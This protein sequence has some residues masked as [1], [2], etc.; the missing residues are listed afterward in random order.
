MNKLYLKIISLHLPLL[1]AC[2]SAFCSEPPVITGIVRNVLCNGAST[3]SITT[4]TNNGT[5]PFSYFWSNGA[6]TASLT[7]ISAGTYSVTVVDGASSSATATFTVT[8]PSALDVSGG[9]IPTCGSLS[10]GVV[11]LFVSGGTPG[12]G[13]YSFKW[14][15]GTTGQN[16]TS[17]AA[18]TYFVTVTDSFAC[19]VSQSFSITSSALP[20]ATPTAT[21]ATICDGKSTVLAAHATAGGAPIST[22][23]WSNGQVT[24]TSSITVAPSASTTYSVTVTNKYNCTAHGSVLVTVNVSPAKPTIT[25]SGSTVLCKGSTK[26]TLSTVAAK[27][28][29]YLWNT[30]ATTKSITVKQIGYYAVTLSNKAGCSTTSDSIKVTSEPICPGADV[31]DDKTGDEDNSVTAAA[32]TALTISAYPNPYTGQFH[33]KMMNGTTDNISLRIYNI[34]GQLIEEKTNLFY[35]TDIVLGGNYAPGVYILQAKQGEESQLLRVVKGE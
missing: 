33:L 32:N 16:A 6:S 31:T 25:A 9:I 28:D 24:G 8:Q 17:L 1:L 35:G 4:T 14:S 12:P 34:T 7:N 22:Y 3:G 5:S 30:G 23:T 10:T 11:D 21:P 26:V 27:G 15:N 19:K 18:G 20:T 2:F 13:G 29:S